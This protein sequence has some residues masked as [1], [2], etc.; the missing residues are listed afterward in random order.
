MNWNCCNYRCCSELFW[1]CICSKVVMFTN[2]VYLVF[3][4]FQLWIHWCHVYR[5]LLYPKLSRS[6]RRKMKIPNPLILDGSHQIRWRPNSSGPRHLSD[7]LL[8]KN[9]NLFLLF[10]GVYIEL[11][12]KFHF[13]WGISICLCQG[14]FVSTC[15]AVS[16]ALYQRCGGVL[17]GS[18][19]GQEA[20]AARLLPKIT[21]LKQFTYIDAI[22]KK[23]TYTNQVKMIA[24]NP[25][26][27]R[28]D[29]YSKK[30]YKY[31]V[32]FFGQAIQEEDLQWNGTTCFGEGKGSQ[33]VCFSL[34]GQLW[35]FKN[36]Y[37]R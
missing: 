35:I 26:N 37:R 3:L 1:V 29:K 15:I 10:L 36:T 2:W 32:E 5:R 17:Q 11:L 27:P 22:G 4:W 21:C 20:R 19:F 30:V 24:C 12:Y 7:I 33:V 28:Q 23:H 16:K 25:C 6:S 13:V 34:V 14:W 31:F 18:W 9:S 8:V